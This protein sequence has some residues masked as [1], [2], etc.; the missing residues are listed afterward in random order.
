MNDKI[1]EKIMILRLVL[2]LTSLI[3]FNANAGVAVVV[4]KA[5]PVNQLEQQK[6][7]KIFKGQLLQYDNGTRIEV[8]TQKKA[9]PITGQFYEQVVK[10][11]TRQVMAKWAKLVFTGKASN[12]KE[13]ANDAQ[14][15]EWVSASSGA[16][17]FVDEKSVN[18]KVK[19]VAKF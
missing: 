10:A 15:I 4:N 11:S 3:A 17:G 19:V 16:I 14:M 9:N 12:P 5:S 1:M 18:D 13:A 6:I 2:L 8:I 7:A